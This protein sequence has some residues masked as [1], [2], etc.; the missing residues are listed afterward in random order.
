MTTSN[1]IGGHDY[2]FRAK[3]VY[4]AGNAHYSD[5]ANDPI[6]NKEQSIQKAP[7]LTSHLE[8][9]TTAMLKEQV[10]LTVDYSSA[11]PGEVKWYDD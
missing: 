2:Y 3:A 7:V 8:E 6:L 4:R 5:L 1:I 9:M 10:A 11:T